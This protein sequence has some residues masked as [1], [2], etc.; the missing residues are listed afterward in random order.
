MLYHLS[1][2]LLKQKV[3]WKLLEGMSSEQ[4]GRLERRLPFLAT[5]ANVSPFIG[6]LG[7]V[8]GIMA[9]FRDIGL[10]GA[11]NLAVV[12]PGIAEALVA[13]AAGLAAAIPAVVAYN[14]FNARI[15]GFQR[16]LERFA[17]EL[18]AVLAAGREAR[19][20]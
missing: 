17:A 16:D 10:Q 11:A 19:A 1:W 4:V 18:A 14:Y 15:N 6:L 2:E 3:Q 12:A 9:A 13:T 5:V 7:T 8:W 20:V